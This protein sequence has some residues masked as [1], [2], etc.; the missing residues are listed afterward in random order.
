MTPRD[1][2][3][4]L[5]TDTLSVPETAAY[6]NVSVETVRRLMLEGQ[7][8]GFRLSRKKVRLYKASVV[9]YLDEQQSA[10]AYDYR[11]QRK[12]RDKRRQKAGQFRHMPPATGKP[13]TAGRPPT[14]KP[15]GRRTVVRTVARTE[16]AS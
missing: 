9:Q 1:F 7:I 10:P 4:G 13:P 2:K 15:A 12:L 3:Q 11:A 14:A 16:R 6:L 5:S 8:Y